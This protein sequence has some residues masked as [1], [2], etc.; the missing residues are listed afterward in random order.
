MLAVAMLA[1]VL[2]AASAWAQSP[3]VVDIPTRAGV[4]QRILVLGPAA[5]KAA[6]VLF[7]GGHG[8][9]QLAPDGEI[10]WGKGNFLIRSRDLFV[11]H[12]LRVAI[13]DAPSDRQ[14]TPFLGGFRQTPEHVTD[15]KAV[16]GWL[17]RQTP[18]PVWL[19]GTSRGTQSAAFVAT[20][21][22]PDRGGPDGIVLSSTILRDPRGRPVPDMALDRVR[23][24][25]LVVHH[26]Q[27]GCQLCAYADV[28]R[29][30]D[31]LTAAPRKELL[32]FDGGVTRGDPCEA[33]AYHGFNGL[34]RDV[35]AKISAWILAR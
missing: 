17:R 25:V 23:V 27:D 6:V 18:T 34:E 7:A 32:A 20:E 15:V 2:S 9:L 31:R 13:I 30:T 3:H 29:L 26:R 16:V 10:G 35:V 33:F 24:P 5:A 4:T 19:V 8:G 12:G 11:E 22:G 28:P 21:I 1:L 14:S